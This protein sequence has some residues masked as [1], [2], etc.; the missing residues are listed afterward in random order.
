MW[1]ITIT[2]VFGNV[3]TKKS[4]P[5]EH[6]P[7]GELVAGDEILEHGSNREKVEADAAKMGM[8]LSHNN[9]EFAL[10]R[11]EIHERRMAFPVELLRNRE[12][13]PTLS[14]LIAR[15][16]SRDSAGVAYIAAKKSSPPPLPSFWS[17]PD[18][19]AS[20]SEPQKR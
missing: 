10:R 4:P 14:P 20:V 1:P 3:S 7:V 2:S 15:K 13:G 17:S 9:R 5:L 11:P 12:A 16:K 6:H 8:G 18:L 19:R